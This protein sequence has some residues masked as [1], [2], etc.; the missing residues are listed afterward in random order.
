MA[1]K[2]W[3]VYC[4]TNKKNNKKYIGITSKEPKRRWGKNGIYYQTQFFHR[5]IN[6]YGWDGFEHDIL[7]MD[8]TEEEAK[9]K[10]VELIK[11]Y[12]TKNRNFGYNLTDGGDGTV[13]IVISEETRT[14]L[15]LSHIG[16][17]A[18][19]KGMKGQYK[20]RTS[21]AH[22]EKWKTKEYREKQTIAHLGNKQSE[23]TKNKIRKNSARLIPIYQLDK[24]TNTVINE[25]C[26]IVE[27]INSIGLKKT[28]SASISSC[29]TCRQKHKTACG[30]KWI[31]KEDY[32]NKTN[33]YYTIL[34]SVDGRN[35]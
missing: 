12:N 17:V 11:K 29:C 30:Y 25:F 15:R 26:S 7:Y 10:E 23:E 16:Q 18:W 35:I 1:E 20:I 3:C 19:N 31:Y 32:D 33:R 14:N 6:K 8:L 22:L 13:G 4:H 5:A 9:Q 2:K 24:K 34:N 21:V 27:A 28:D